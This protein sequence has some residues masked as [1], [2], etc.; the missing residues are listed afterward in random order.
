MHSKQK[1]P[2]FAS[3]ILCYW[4]EIGPTKAIFRLQSFRIG[5]STRVSNLL[6]SKSHLDPFTTARRPMRARII[7]QSI[8]HKCFPKKK[9]KVFTC[10]QQKSHMRLRSHGLPTYG[11]VVRF[12]TWYPKILMSE[13]KDT[14]FESFA[15]K[16]RSFSSSR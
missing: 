3:K 4:V 8:G 15:F 14:T 16:W 9:K 5:S 1:A 6:P 10:S 12:P 11:L 2:T 7:L 13:T